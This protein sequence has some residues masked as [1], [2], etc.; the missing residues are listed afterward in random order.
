[1]VYPMLIVAGGLVVLAIARGKGRLLPQ[2]SVLFS[3]LI[4]NPFE[5][6]VGQPVSISVNI[7]N[8][9]SKKGYYPVTIG[10]DLMATINVTLNPG[11][12]KVVSF[13]YTPTQAR[14]FTVNVDGLT[15]SFTVYPVPVAQFELTNLTI[16][17]PDPYV[18]EEVTIGVTV[19][20]IGNAP[21]TKTITFEV[22]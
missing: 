3:N 12:S 4:I 1:M 17:P 5:V 10:G 15:S 18:G 2:E 22:V 16:A 13:T 8:T 20:N 6:Y 7:T 21:G 14:V 9:S 19:T 11:E